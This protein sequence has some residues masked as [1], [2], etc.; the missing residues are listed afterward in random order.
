MGNLNQRK[1]HDPVSARAGG[2][3]DELATNS[4]RHFVH[5][6]WLFTR[7]DAMNR[8][9]AEKTVGEICQ[10]LNDE[11]SKVVPV[12]WHTKMR[13]IIER[14]GGQ[15]ALAE[16]PYSDCPRCF[17]GL[18][19]G[20]ECAICWGTGRITESLLNEDATAAPS[21]RAGIDEAKE[22]ERFLEDAQAS[23]SSDSVVE[24]SIDGQC[25]NRHG[26]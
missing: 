11:M 2:G 9:Q 1:S 8:E 23:G 14:A 25:I 12:T 24:S 20:R 22:R 4:N 13:D 6:G 17:D 21:E 3:E 26:Q 16:H 5:I 15:D 7:E 10:F 18:Y 19:N